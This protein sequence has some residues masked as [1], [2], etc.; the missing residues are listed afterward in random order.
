MDKR[1]HR[2]FTL[3]ELL[4]VIAI[5][6]IL[7]ALLLPA[8]QQVREAARK[9]QCQDHLHNLVIAVMNYESNFKLLPMGVGPNSPSTSPGSAK[10]A[11]GWSAYILPF[12]EQKPMFDLVGVA[13]GSLN[14]SLSVPA[15]QTAVKQQIDVFVCPSDNSP[16]IMEGMRARNGSGFNPHW[17]NAGGPM[18]F[19]TA[20]ANYVANAGHKT[21]GSAGNTGAMYRLSGVR[22]SDVQD[23]VSNL[24]FIGERDQEC[25][26]GT[27][28]GSH[29]GNNNG[30]RGNNYVLGNV[31]QKPNGL[32]QGTNNYGGILG[33]M[34]N[35]SCVFGFSSKHPGGT[36]FAL[37]DG[38]VTF[39]SENI[40]HNN[41]Y[42]A[43]VSGSLVCEQNR[44]GFYAN[45]TVMPPY[46]G[47]PIGVYQRL[48]IM[49]DGLP[50]R[51]P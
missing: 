3:I 13:A 14:N 7:V 41:N 18:N 24:F 51:V 40:D 48:G 29:A 37:G 27:W 11:F 33:S 9:S 2:G 39:V 10:S 49:D 20:T 44:E 30:P 47:L 38:K 15:I 17:N 32:Y 35:P 5:I 36:Q 31:Y 43:T 4:V 26:A 8:V 42:C 19:Y 23:G 45:T 22:I 25:S 16:E 6:A 50:V 1:H 12:S 46:N 34:D 28:V 21:L